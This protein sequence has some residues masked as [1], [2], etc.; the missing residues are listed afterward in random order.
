MALGTFTWM[1]SVKGG[2]E[3]MI[4]HSFII[5][6]F[7]VQDKLILLH[8][9]LFSLINGV[10]LLFSNLFDSFE[11]VFLSLEIFYIDIFLRTLDN[12]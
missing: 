8:D 5:I 4:V 6:F 2:L 1:D 10:L 7:D 11:I 3:K 12:F 9:V